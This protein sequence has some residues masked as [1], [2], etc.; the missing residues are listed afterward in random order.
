MA[1]AHG[2]VGDGAS[3]ALHEFYTP[4]IVRY[5][6]GTGTGNGESWIY[7]AVFVRDFALYVIFFWIARVDSVEIW[8]CE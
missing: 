1:L 7:L 8:N 5:T 6:R 2:C 3:E 4:S